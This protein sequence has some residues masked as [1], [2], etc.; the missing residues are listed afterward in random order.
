MKA[1]PF[2]AEKIQDAAIVCRFCNRDLPA[3][4]TPVEPV[5]MRTRG[6]DQQHDD[7]RDEHRD[8]SVEGSSRRRQHERDV[9]ERRT[10]EQGADVPAVSGANGNRGDA[11][12][13]G[14]KS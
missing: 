3:T 11:E 2:C 8:V 10:G 5:R 6:V 1:C 7:R 12:C 4:P 9:S 13:R 14:T